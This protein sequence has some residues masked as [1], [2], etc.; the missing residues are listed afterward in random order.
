MRSGHNPHKDKKESV[1]GFIHQVIIPV[2][3]PDGGDYFR[4]GLQI[5]R[6]CLESLSKTIHSKTFVTVVNNGSSGEVINY[7]DKL[8]SQGKIHELI[9]TVNIGKLNAVLKGIS[10]NVFPLVTVADADAL[11]LNGWQKATYD[12]YGAFPKAGAVCP[13]PSSKSYRTYTGNIW[14]EN[15]FSSRF[16]FTETKN[17]EALKAF[18]QSIGNPDFY[19]RQQLEKYLTINS[20]GI[21]AVVGAG[22]FLATYRGSIF[23][24]IR[25]R[26]SEFKL[27][28]DSEREIL[29]LPVVRNGLWRLSTH[30][31]YA[32]HMG[33]I[34][35]PWMKDKLESL[36]DN[37]FEPQHAPAFKSTAF[38]KTGD[39]IK[40][41]IFGKL[42]S[43][44]KIL[45]LLLRYKGLSSE[46][47]KKYLR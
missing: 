29:D 46:T 40:N 47:A 14:S 11:F 44:K 4:D 19:N 26:F 34:A 37:D 35:E 39:F 13:V 32:F 41:R 42:L 33:N 43:N 31:N 15:L 16:G 7:L 8:Y 27:G 2:Y 38:T 20:D 23:K 1:S 24:N 25:R 17:P 5:L 30:D 22:H 9:H 12:V 10:G 3:L 21:T 36:H 18:A 45:V 28:G 6:Y